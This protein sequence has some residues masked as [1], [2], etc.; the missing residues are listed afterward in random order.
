MKD[1]KNI[2][3]FGSTND[4]QV[5]WLKCLLIKCGVCNFADGCVEVERCRQMIEEQRVGLFIVSQSIGP[6]EMEG[7]NAAARQLAVPVLHL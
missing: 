2:V 6:I 3:I 7:I 5:V 1:P 4:E